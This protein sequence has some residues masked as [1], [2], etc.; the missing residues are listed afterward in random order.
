[1]EQVL[2][3][4]GGL[5]LG[6]SA[7][8]VLLAWTG[9][10]KGRY[11]ARWRCWGW[12]LLCLRLALPLPLLPQVQFPAPIRMEIPA[13]S[14]VTPAAPPTVEAAVSPPP[15]PPA[16]EPG[17][18]GLSAPP[19]G[20][21]A[22]VEPRPAPGPDPVRLLFTLWL[23]G[24]GGVLAW[25]LAA[26]LRFLS[27]LRRWAV[28]VTDGAVIAAYDR[29]G[30]RLALRRRP[31][32]LVCQGLQVPMLAGVLRPAILLPREPIAGEAL[33]LALLHELIHYRR[34]DVW[35]KLLAVWV[36]ALYWFD[37]LMWSMVRLMERD[38]ELA[39]DEEVLSRLP[40]GARAAYGQ[41]ILDAAARLQGGRQKGQKGDPHD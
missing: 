27:Y 21:A 2:L 15:V 14:T 37:P 12:L 19:E 23:L 36:N 5:T 16:Q 9:R 30:D 33:D 24:A 10:S 3:T 20:P 4:L 25:D 31:R 7:V 13:P 35:R 8:V 38:G 41:T 40:A 11:G 22:S 18:P 26:H 28:P 6:G 1:M 34:R 17:Q 32:L 29:L 39:C